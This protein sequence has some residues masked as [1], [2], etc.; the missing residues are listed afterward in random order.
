MVT[1]ILLSLPNPKVMKECYE[2]MIS[3]FLWRGKP[4][5]YRREI[6]ECPSKLEDFN[7]I[8]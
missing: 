1:H 7:Y 6:L 8:L 5:K 3:D 4:P 2:G